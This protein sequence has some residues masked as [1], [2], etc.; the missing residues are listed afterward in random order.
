MLGLIAKYIKEV[1]VLRR[2]VFAAIHLPEDLPNLWGVV[3]E[4]ATKGKKESSAITAEDAKMLA[5]NIQE[6]DSKAFSTDKDL[7]ME[8]M[9]LQVPKSKPLGMVLI[10]AKKDCPACGSSLRLRKDRPA[11]VIVYDNNMGTLPGSHFHKCCTSPKCSC[12]QYYGFYT[13]GGEVVFNSDWAT[14]PYFVS[15]RETVYSMDLLHHFNAEIIIG[16]LSFKQCADVYNFLHGYNTS[17]S[18]TSP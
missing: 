13:T 7:L 16:Q 14:L 18:S 8:L 4:Y 12:T 9:A 10:S 11:S 6:F 2:L 15:S 17:A 1:S 5:E 3:I